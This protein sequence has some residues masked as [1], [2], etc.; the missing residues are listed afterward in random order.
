MKIIDVQD[1]NLALG[2]LL[3][4]LAEEDILI[5]KEG[6]AQARMERFTDEDWEDWLFEHDPKAIQAAE[7]ARE[8]RKR[9]EG[10]PLAALRE[11]LGI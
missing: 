6:H 1:G 2:S 10:V 4:A 7:A 9:G 5:T 11:E 8:R 3:S